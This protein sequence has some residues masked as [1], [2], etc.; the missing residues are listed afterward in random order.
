MPEV[1]GPHDQTVIKQQGNSRFDSRSWRNCTI[2]NVEE[3]VFSP[4]VFFKFMDFFFF[5]SQ[6]FHSFII[7]LINSGG[8]GLLGKN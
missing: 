3:I 6:F 5:F 1:W 8:F 7:F 4:W 2:F